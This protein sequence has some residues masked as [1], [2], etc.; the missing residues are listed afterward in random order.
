MIKFLPSYVGSKSFYVQYLEQYKGRKFVEPFCGSAV[1]SAN[2]ASKAILNDIDPYIT[3][4]L[5]RFDEQIVSDAFTREEYYQVREFPN[6][7]QYAYCLQKMSFSGVFRYSKNGYNV[8]AKKIPIVF[9][10]EDYQDALERWRQL[11]PIITNKQY[12]EVEIK[13]DDVLIL[14]PPY[15]NTVAS[16]CKED[17]DY[18]FYW[19]WVKK[20]QDICKTI[21]LFD[22][23]DN[24][25]KF[26]Q[27]NMHVLSPERK[28]RINGARRGNKEIM[29]ELLR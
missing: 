22:F 3:K 25:P 17:F 7:W 8:P 26:V 6:W 15:K 4:I 13:E 23:Q 28:S 10:W 9:V 18:G 12:Y 27:K 16:Y 1:I 11:Q 29:V 5:S 14:D 19:E 2:L 20:Q 24:F 21:I